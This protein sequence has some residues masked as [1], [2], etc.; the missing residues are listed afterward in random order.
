MNWGYGKIRKMKLNSQIQEAICNEIKRGTP[1]TSACLIAGISKDTYYR[2]YRKGE[3]AKTGRFKEFYNKIE[4]AKAYAIALRVENIR[5]AGRNGSWQADA[6]WLERMVPESFGRKDKMEVKS[7]NT[8]TNVNMEVKSTD[9]V[10]EE[11]ADT[12]TRFIERRIKPE[13]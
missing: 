8:N 9:K 13:D 2:W 1:I 11:N 12:I 5:K 6:W 4:E 7:D 3:K 10:L